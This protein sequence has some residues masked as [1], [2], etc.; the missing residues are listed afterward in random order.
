M[1]TSTTSQRNELRLKH[2]LN[3][4]RL[5]KTNLVLFIGAY[6]EPNSTTLHIVIV[7]QPEEAGLELHA[8]HL[9][10][11]L[12]ETVAFGTRMLLIKLIKLCVKH[13]CVLC[14]NEEVALGW[15]LRLIENQSVQV[16]SAAELNLPLKPAQ[17]SN[18]SPWALRSLTILFLPQ[19]CGEFYHKPKQYLES[20]I[21][22]LVR[23]MAPECWIT[24]LCRLAKLSLPWVESWLSLRRGLSTELGLDEGALLSKTQSELG[25]IAACVACGIDTTSRQRKSSEQRHATRQRNARDSESVAYRSLRDVE[26]SSIMFLRSYAYSDRLF[27]E[28]SN[29]VIGQCSLKPGLGG[30]HSTHDNKRTSVELLQNRVNWSERL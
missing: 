14:F 6:L 8:T 28:P 1:E 15:L 4:V 21:W 7:F 9:T 16:G 29:L 26:R 20:D 30:L 10:F 18:T 13:K 17:L 5:S 19:V 24:R 25:E 3:Q 23:R 2:L 27:G 12:F 11:N 22:F